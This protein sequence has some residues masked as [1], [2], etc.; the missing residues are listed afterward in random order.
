MSPSSAAP[1][2]SDQHRPRAQ[3]PASAR[4][5]RLSRIGLGQRGRTSQARGCSLSRPRATRR[6][7][8][9]PRHRP[10][11]AHQVQ[12]RLDPRTQPLLAVRPMPVDHLPLSAL[13]PVDL[14]GTEGV[15]AQLPVDNSLRVLVPDRVG[16][17]AADLGRDDL[18]SVRLEPDML[19]SIQLKSSSSSARPVALF[20]APRTVTGSWRDQISRRG[21]A[22]PSCTATSASRTREFTHARKSSRSVIPSIMPL[23]KPYPIVRS[24]PDAS[25]SK[26]PSTF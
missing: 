2:V 21:L 11:R 17:V 25:A 12:R 13:A 24:V 18:E 4:A 20:A 1:L 3:L 14:G 5:G 6:L 22:S 9:P 23:P 8:V 26:V 7:T 10:G 16:H 19:C 15:S